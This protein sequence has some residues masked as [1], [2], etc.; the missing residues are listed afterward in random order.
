[1]ILV[2]NEYGWRMD[3]WMHQKLQNIVFSLW[4]RKNLSP[5]TG[6]ETQL[7][8][9][10]IIIYMRFKRSKMISLCVG[11]PLLILRLLCP[12]I[13]S[14]NVF[15][16]ML[17]YHSFSSYCVTMTHSNLIVWFVILDL[18]LTKQC[19]FAS[20]SHTCYMKYFVVRY[21]EQSPSHNL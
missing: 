7:F 2:C 12:R 5:L 20:P 17:M 3:I 18:F 8:T 15:L 21:F 11:G 9:P 16:L 1:M 4:T 14:F 13:G 19:Y 6:S 10:Y